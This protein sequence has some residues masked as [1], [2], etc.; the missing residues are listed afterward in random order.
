MVGVLIQVA[1]GIRGLALRSPTLPP[2][3]H[4]NA[5][6]LGHDALTIVDPASPWKEEQQRLLDALA[7][8]RVQRILLT[9]HHHDHISGAVALQQALGVPIVAHAA[10]AERVDFDVE[11]LDAGVLDC[12]GLP[13][14]VVHTPGHAPGHLALFDPSS[15]VAVMGDL[16]AGEGTILIDPD[17]TGDLGL[18]FESLRRIRALGPT[19][20]LPAHGP[21]LEDAIGA[22]DHYIEH[23]YARNDQILDALQHA[24]RPETLAPLVYPEL[25]APF[26]RLAAVQIRAHLNWLQ[27]EGLVRR[28]GDRWLRGAGA[29]PSEG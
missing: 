27:A 23:R 21:V 20:L 11:F 13:I 29:R 26:L 15:G 25:P 10:T 2:A 3:T 14:Q 12:G 24:D 9:H 1:P 8:F 28:T 22:I 7:P 5:W 4:T 18:Y 16:V 6:M 17:D 19:A